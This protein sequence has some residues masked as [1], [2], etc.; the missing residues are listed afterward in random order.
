MMLNRSNDVELEFDFDKILEK[1]KENPV[2]YVQYCHARIKSIFRSIGFEV[3]KRTII[4]NK[5]I[6]FNIYEKE[7]LKK[8]FEWPKV[9][10]ISSSKCE[11][12]RI[13]F[14]FTN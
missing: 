6:D 10:R 14:I 5:D 4:N 11:P 3:K 1:S 7:I 12:H 13:P 8:I 2:F 9:I